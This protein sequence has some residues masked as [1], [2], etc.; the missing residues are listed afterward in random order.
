MSSDIEDAP[1]DIKLVKG[2][3]QICGIGNRTLLGLSLEVEKQRQSK[4]CINKLFYNIPSFR[5]Q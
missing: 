3:F 1:K 2:D 4:D 5:S